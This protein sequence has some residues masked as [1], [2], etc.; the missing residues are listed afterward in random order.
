MKKFMTMFLAV[1]L[2]MSLVSIINV[3]A[4]VVGKFNILTHKSGKTVT[5]T[6]KNTDNKKTQTVKLQLQKKSGSNWNNSGS[7]ITKTVKSNKTETI[8]KTFG[9]GTYRY[10]ATSSGKTVYTTVVTI[11]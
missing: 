7:S 5:L 3:D 4:S 9:K 6:A 10:K 2:V 1:M 11:K 8:K